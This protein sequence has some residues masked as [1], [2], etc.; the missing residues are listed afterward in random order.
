M[1]QEFILRSQMM[2]DVWYECLCL[3]Y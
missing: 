1:K 3:V 2:V